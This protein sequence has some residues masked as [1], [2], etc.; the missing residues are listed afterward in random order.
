M[1]TSARLL[2][3]SKTITLAN[4]SCLS[5]TGD[6]RRNYSTLTLVAIACQMHIEFEIMA[7]GHFRLSV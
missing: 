4:P 6:V 5:S 3:T 7:S 1:E 2:L